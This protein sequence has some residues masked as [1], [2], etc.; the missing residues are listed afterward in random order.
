MRAMQLSISAFGPYKDV[1]MIDFEKLAGDALFLITGPTGAGKTTIFDA[2]CYALYGRAS[3]SD[4]DHDTFR[5]HFAAPDEQT[6]V[7][8]RFQ[9]QNKEYEVSRSPKQ[10]KRKER[11]EGF[12]EQPP[13]AELYEYIHG[14]KQLLYS[15]IKDV[16]EAIENLLQLDYEQ[17]RKMVMIPQGEFRRLISENSREREAILQKIFRTYFYKDMTNRLSDKS[18]KLEES[19]RDI[20]KIE[21]MEIQQY[22]WDT[23]GE[24]AAPD[25]DEAISRLK[26]FQHDEKEQLRIKKEE[27]EGA[28]KKF[29]QKQ[30]DYY[31]AKEIDQLFQEKNQLK[32]R[33]EELHAKQETIN[34]K[35]E[36]LKSAGRA[37]LLTGYEKQ[38]NQRRHELNQLM[39]EEKKKEHEVQTLEK[40][41]EEIKI[42]FEKEKGAESEREKIKEQIKRL[43]EEYKL[44]DQ[45]HQADEQARQLKQQLEDKQSLIKRAELKSAKLEEEQEQLEE[46]SSRYDELTRHY[47]EQEARVKE[48]N[49]QIDRAQQ[50]I[51]EYRKLN[52]LREEYKRVKNKYL[53]VRQKREDLEKQL[54]LLEEQQMQQQAA[55]LAHSLQSNDPCPVCGS[56]HH[57]NKAEFEGNQVTEEEIKHIRKTLSLTEKDEEQWQR[58][59]LRIES[60]GQ[61]QK[62]LIDN[63]T[64]EISTKEDQL[65]LSSIEQLATDLINQHK[66]SQQEL[67]RIKQQLETMK[68]K[69]SRKKEVKK[70]LT[71]LKKKLEEQKKEADELRE[72]WIR[73]ESDL[74]NI[75]RQ[76][77]RQPVS[78][79]EFKQTVEQEKAKY[80]VMVD[81]WNQIQ[82]QYERQK[83]NL[84]KGKVELSSLQSQIVQEKEKLKQAQRQFHEQL[85]EKGFQT[86]DEYLKARMSPEL[87]DTVENEIKSFEEQWYASKERFQVL[88][89]KLKEKDQPDLEFI[90][91]ELERLNSE[92]ELLNKSIQQCEM[93]LE[94]YDNSIKRLMEL[95]KKRKSLEERYFDIGE[96]ARL[97]RGDNDQRLSFERF[98]LSA[99][100]DE[101][102]LQANIRLDRMTDH[103]FELIRS[104]QIAKRGAQSGLDL[105]VMDHYTGQQRSVRTLSGG[106]GFK[107]AL[108]LALGMAD[109]VQAHA[110]GVELDTLFIDE[111]FGTLDELSVEQALGCLH[112]LQNGNRVLGI[113]SHVPKLKEEIKAKLQIHPSPA[114]STVTLSLS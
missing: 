70:Q 7:T 112:D 105:E 27:L 107:A 60:Q 75:R 102:L 26:S 11:G 50:V 86:Y 99:F 35:R 84:N 51:K 38:V 58:E 31:A 5:S 104:D 20:Q 49:Q 97:A 73:R 18:K 30:T 77:S 100:L 39:E 69:N 55:F 88:E 101:I 93:K 8:F 80:Q 87:Q 98:V 85:I 6:E 66:A 28:K 23:E 83:E 106:E 33:L 57:P 47:Y 67:L 54:S 63:M 108:S 44:I 32:S 12:T 82:E 65:S 15:R 9:L 114:G 111:G 89:D 113:I 109:V 71:E 22:E 64:R 14:K 2:M 52:N 74:E 59:C 41:F 36:Q 4:R 37:E 13:K 45:Y 25:T 103:R 40:Q 3:G 29:E 16:N 68:Q 90:K 21:E 53:E 62:Q 1:Q 46:E 48:Q 92:I 19:I 56:T 79:P 43:E 96:L 17:F 110:G 76:L 94:R 10:L 78:A 24:N 61:S 81:K 34:Q 72:K 42:E 91:Q 95:R